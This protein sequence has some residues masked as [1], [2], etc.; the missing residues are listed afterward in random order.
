MLCLAPA[1][2]VLK[3]GPVRRTPNPTCCLNCRSHHE[4]YSAIRIRPRHITTLKSPTW[5]ATIPVQSATHPAK[6]LGD[7]SPGTSI[8][9][10][11]FKFP[12]FTAADWSVGTRQ[13]RFIV[14]CVW[15]CLGD[16]PKSC[17][18]IWVKHFRLA[19]CMASHQHSLDWFEG[20][21]IGNHGFYHQIWG[22][23]V[24]F[25]LNQSNETWLDL[26]EC[27]VCLSIL[28]SISRAVIREEVMPCCSSS[29]ASSLRLCHGFCGMTMWWNIWNM[30]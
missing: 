26:S 25:P 22:F 15:G 12:T 8:L 13:S 24:K 10:G 20:K 30:I 1:V 14:T 21:S 11:S 29:V 28:S 6:R 2:R 7:T 19:L 4:G 16:S 9:A 27:F 18:D 5:V 17:F 3:R 23:P